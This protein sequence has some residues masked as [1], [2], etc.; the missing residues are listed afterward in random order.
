MKQLVLFSDDIALLE[1]W[2]QL[3]SKYENVVCIDN[4]E[5]MYDIADSVVILNSCA[6]NKECDRLFENLIAKN[7]R[8]LVLDKVPDF[9]HAQ[10]LLL[11]GVMGY[12]NA[13]MSISYINSAVEAM[14][15]NMIWLIPDITTQFVKSIIEQ[16]NSL[17]EIDHQIFSHLTHKE[18]DIA[19]LI[20]KGYSNS[21]IS[22]QLD[23]SINTVKTHI[24]HIY[25]KLQVKDRISFS[26][27]FQ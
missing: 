12:G 13:I 20:K 25:E 4:Q 27:L 2:K 21:E 3:L 24:K 1:R 9:H 16:S 22:E 23:I 15:N 7:N 5:E 26:L 19:I 6:C 10:R 18:Q 17:T 11:R 8:L 14:I